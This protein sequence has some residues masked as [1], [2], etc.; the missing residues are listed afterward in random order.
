MNLTGL[1]VTTSIFA[2]LLTLGAL[3]ADPTVS[4]V[5]AR[6]RWPWSRLVDIDYVLTG[7]STQ[8][9]DIAITA[10]DGSDT[11]A[12]PLASLTGDLINV[13]PGPHR[14]V[15]DPTVTSY[16][17]SQMLTQFSVNLTPTEAP[18]YMIVDLTKAA[19]AAGQC[20]YVYESDLT[21]GLWGS[22]ARNPVTNQGAVVESVIWTG[23]TTNDIYRTDKLVLRR[24]RA[25]TFGMGNSA[26]LSTT[27][28]KDF[29][30]GVF[31]MTQHQWVLLMGSN[32]SDHDEGP[33]LRPVEEMPYNA[34]RG[35]TTNT[36]SIDWP[37]TGFEVLPASFVG[38]LRAATGI[39]DFDL[40]TEAQ[41]EYF[42]RAGTTTMY[43]D[44]DAA[45]NVSGDNA[46]SNVW[47]DVL[48]RYIY[49]ASSTGTP[50]YGT[51][52]VGCYLPNA[53]GLY[54]THGNVREYC[55]DWEASLAGGED[56]QGPDS[57]TYRI[58]RGGSWNRNAAYA[59]C[60]D[61]TSLRKL[62]AEHNGN[63]GFRIVRHL[64]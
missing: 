8:R 30:A 28:T 22:W 2:T 62:P 9:V 40:P 59:I 24:I 10:K 5:V 38:Q 32:P 37:T 57:G 47:L 4:D 15:W 23:V 51:A 63:I 55:L 1:K 11:L 33:S 61:R 41:W 14:I 25:G 52:L 60:A 17:N 45:A 56:P 26:S 50:N 19:G 12:I 6:Q 7:D 48:G 29:Y 27:L 46:I 35:A 20:E 31:E 3:A 42:C 53:W 18:L 21:N 49:N 58:N 13:S 64:P 36:P 54:D 44:G 16:T 34:I 39:A 43:N